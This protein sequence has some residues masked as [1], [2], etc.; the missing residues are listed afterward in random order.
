MALAL[1]GMVWYCMDRRSNLDSLP[2]DTGMYVG[3]RY[4]TSIDN[5]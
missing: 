1:H 4:Q 3:H 2:L 5:F